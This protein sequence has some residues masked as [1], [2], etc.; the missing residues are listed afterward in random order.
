MNLATRF[1]ARWLSNGWSQ[2]GDR[3]LVACS[4]GVDS[5]TLMH[6]LR[7]SSPGIEGHV[8]AAYFDHRLRPESGDD[9]LWLKGV[10]AGWGVPLHLGRATTIPANEEEARNARYAFLEGLLKDGVRWV[11]TA[12][13]QDDQIET[14]L[15]R[16][17]RGTGVEGLR[18]IPEVRDPGILRPLLAFSRSEIEGYAE[19]H[20]LGFRRDRTNLSHDPA[21]N[22]IRLSLLPALQQ[23]HPGARE[24]LLRL[25][26]HA[27]SAT[28][29]LDLLLHPLQGAILL[30][31]GPDRLVMD[32]EAFLG[33]DE[34]IQGELFRRFASSLRVKPSE[35]GTAIAL[36]FMRKG[37]SG[38]GVSVDHLLHLSR[39]FSQCTLLRADR[40]TSASERER[41][42][43]PLAI[44]S[45]ES[46]SERLL[47]HG[48]TFEVQWGD[49]PTDEGWHWLDLPSEGVQFP[50]QVRGW[51]AGDR[52]RTEQGEKK[53][54]KIFGELRIPLRDRSRIPLLLDSEGEVLWIAGKKIGWAIPVLANDGY[55]RG[56]GIRP[57]AN[58]DE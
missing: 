37:S 25:G 56:V 11:L 35:A 12:H 33:L 54:K 50:L 34:P 7:F 36:E 13:H 5:M 52:M 21:R 15:F 44:P 4:G 20:R 10:A 53:L 51:V 6:L 46:G 22:R 3:L 17:L 57:V 48:R 1:E 39:D 43:P 27:E 55:N 41:S 28:R 29:A 31:S 40:L 16:I 26:R 30:E 24:G 45:L 58:G 2:A 8:E 38:A 14:I 32:R 18:G 19:A 23:I 42:S 49:P 47:L 9:G